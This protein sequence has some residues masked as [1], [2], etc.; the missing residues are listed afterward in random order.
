MRKGAKNPEWLCF[1]RIREGA[2]GKNDA[3]RV[4]QTLFIN[5]GEGEGGGVC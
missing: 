4:R 2:D 1:F 3:W 5:L